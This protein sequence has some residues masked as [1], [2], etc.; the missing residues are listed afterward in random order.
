MGAWPGRGVRGQVSKARGPH[1]PCSPG[2]DPSAARAGAPGW[3][4]LNLW[5]LK[6]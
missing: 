6:A 4:R 3:Q 1:M 5:W 2:S